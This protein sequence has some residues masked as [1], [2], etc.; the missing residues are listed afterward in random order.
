MRGHFEQVAGPVGSVGSNIDANLTERFKGSPGHIFINYMRSGMS[1]AVW[2]M[3]FLGGL[4]R[5]QNG[6]RDWG[7]AILAL[8]PFPLLGLQAYGGE[9]LL[10]IYLFSVPF[11][12][13]FCATLFYPS[14]RAGTSWWSTLSL[15][16]VSILMLISFMFT[17]FG[18][19]RM[20]YF[21]P[22][23]VA[24][25]EYIY[26]VA[27][28]GSQLVA[29]TGTLAWRYQDYRAY[30][31]TT[32]PRIARENDLKQLAKIMRNSKYT[33]SYLIL[34]RSQHASGELFIGWPPG[35]WDLFK[36]SMLTSKEFSLL[37]ANEDAEVYVLNEHCREL[38]L[39]FCS[40]Q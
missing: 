32:V 1:L 6:S 39:A 17:R 5:V 29:I 25:M 13:F 20:M 4:R 23:E 35:T 30:K 26:E 27:E 37:Y 9:L 33:I 15:Y 12:A 40:D 11:M 2:G 21:T 24:A 19:E 34:T 18:N 7:L 22:A 36:Q 38:N 14:F 31:Y 10:R 28:P 8:T 16:A 3:A